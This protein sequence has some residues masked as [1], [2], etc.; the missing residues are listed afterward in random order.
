MRRTTVTEIA[1]DLVRDGL[2]DNHYGRIVIRDRRGLEAAACECYAVVRR[3]YDRLVEGRESP[4]PHR[5]TRT[6]K[7]GRP[8]AQ[9]CSHES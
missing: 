6:S 8:A 1:S 5:R 2:I 3:E 9:A 4:T 7:R